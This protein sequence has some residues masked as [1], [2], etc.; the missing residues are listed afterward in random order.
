MTR[1]YPIGYEQSEERVS[2]LM[3]DSN[4][5]LIDCRFNPHSWRHEWCKTALLG[6]WGDR[7]HWAGAYLGNGKHPSN[8]RSAG[9]VEIE[10]INPQ[11]GIRGLMYYLHQGCD[12][13]LLCVCQDYRSCHLQAVVTL[14]KIAMPE[15]EVILPELPPVEETYKFPSGAKVFAKLRGKEKT[16]AVVLESRWSPEGDYDETRLRV[17]QYHELTEKWLV[18]DYPKP[19]QSYKLSK[20]ATIVPGL[21]ANDPKP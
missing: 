7:Y 12:L 1:V 18:S 6:Q 17:A 2:E 19:V 15:V 10:L 16:P 11:Q 21:D 3:K 4:V 8:Q 9:K 5:H 14:L 13:I 20:R